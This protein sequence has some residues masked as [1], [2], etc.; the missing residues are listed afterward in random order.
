MTRGINFDS[1]ELMQFVDHIRNRLRKALGPALFIV[2]L[3]YFGYHTF[4]GDHGLLSLRDLNKE[5]TELEQKAAEVEARKAALETKVANLRRDNLDLDL[6]DERAR[7][8]LGFH[9]PNEIIIFNDDK[10]E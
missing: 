4:E 2:T 5:M 8:V 1:L 7:D 3:V 10:T 6:L 9:E